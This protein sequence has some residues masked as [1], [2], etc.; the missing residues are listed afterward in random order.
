MKPL[1]PV[2]YDHIG[3]E[4]PRLNQYLAQVAALEQAIATG[5]GNKHELKEQLSVLKKNREDHPYIQ[6]QKNFKNKENDYK[7]QLAQLSSE[8]DPSKG[9]D[10]KNKQLLKHLAKANAQAEFYEKYKDQNYEAKLAFEKAKLEKYHLPRIIDFRQKTHEEVLK[11]V[12]EAKNI[13][14]EM[15]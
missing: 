4:Y 5:E 13:T 1:S 12:S 7:K 8:L 2:L 14:P 15:I 9:F 3:R 11:A 10:D 6:A